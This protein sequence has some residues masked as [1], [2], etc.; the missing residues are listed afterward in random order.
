MPPEGNA[1]GYCVWHQDVPPPDRW[2]RPK[3]RYVKTFTNLWAVPCNGGESGLVPG[4]HR[5]PEG[6]ERTLQCRFRSGRNVG[7]DIYDETCLPQNAMPNNVRFPVE[8]GTMVIF[9]NAIWHTSMPNLG[10][11]GGG[12]DGCSRCSVEI[13][14]QSSET[15]YTGPRAVVWGDV[16]GGARVGITE[17]TLRRLAEEGRLPVPRRRLLGLPDEGMEPS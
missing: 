15:P 7:Y 3:Q 4:S 1:D 2:P 12:L 16:C 8:A 17:R 6:P 13:D 5:L 14:Y 10:G 9:D 11:R